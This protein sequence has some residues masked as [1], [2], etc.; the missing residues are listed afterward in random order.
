METLKAAVGEFYRSISDTYID[1][2]SCPILVACAIGTYT[3]RCLIDASGCV[4]IDISIDISIH[5]CLYLSIYLLT[6]YIL[7]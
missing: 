5:L 6:I 7:I 2:I 4:S 3:D 1:L